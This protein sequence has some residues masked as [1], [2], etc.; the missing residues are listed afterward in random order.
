[1]HQ[2]CVKLD[3]TAIRLLRF[4]E[5]QV[6]KTFRWEKDETDCQ[7]IRPSKRDADLH[8]PSRD[9]GDVVYPR[10]VFTTITS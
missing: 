1:M 10:L 8:T 7:L 4:P 6:R 9:D 2:N 5:G 3:E